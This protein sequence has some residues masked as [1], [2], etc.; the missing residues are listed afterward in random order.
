MSTDGAEA[1]NS[2]TFGLSQVVAHPKMSVPRELPSVKTVMMFA[3][4]LLHSLELG[5]WLCW[6]S[7]LWDTLQ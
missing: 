5:R 7:A 1:W 3:W 6:I 4:A 2:G